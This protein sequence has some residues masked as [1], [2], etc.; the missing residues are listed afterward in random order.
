LLA[1]TRLLISSKLYIDGA[2]L[3]ELVVNNEGLHGMVERC[4]TKS[5]ASGSHLV[6]IEGWKGEHIVS[7]F[8]ARF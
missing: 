1:L 5:L 7:H 8:D 2:D 4:A 3:A 6:Y